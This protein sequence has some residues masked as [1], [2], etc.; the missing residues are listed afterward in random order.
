MVS[1]KGHVINWTNEGERFESA[2]MPME[3]ALRVAKTLRNPHNSTVK[4]ADCFGT[5]YHWSRSK[6]LRNPHL[7]NHWSARAVA[8]LTDSD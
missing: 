2:D 1:A 6:T 3:E 5:V 7:L 8:D 4:V